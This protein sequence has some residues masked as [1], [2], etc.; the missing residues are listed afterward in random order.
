MKSRKRKIQIAAAILAAYAAIVVMLL[1]AESNAEGSSIHSLGDAVWYSLITLTTV[2]YGDIS[3]VTPMGK[4]LG[5]LLALCS[6]GVFTALIGLF[7]NYISG[8]ARPRR[9][10]RAARN[11]KW[12]AIDEENEQ[13]E[14][15]A[16]SVF[17]DDPDAVIVFRYSKEKHLTGRHV[18]RL[19]E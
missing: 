8:Q 6:L 14:A 18:V 2:G 13:S 17:A 19:G 7:I 4:V 1:A 15:F 3:P 5:A 16:R 11:R 9:R 12:Y 10:L